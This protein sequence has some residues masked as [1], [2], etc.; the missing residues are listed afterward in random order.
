MT[1]VGEV[2]F[3]R[4]Y[5]K[6]FCGVDGCY[7]ADG[8]LGVEGKRYSKTVQKHCCKLA[9]DVSFAATSE[10]MQEMLGV[11]ICPETVRTVV[12]GHGKEMARFQANDTVSAEAFRKA[13]GAVEFTTDAGKVNTR[14]EGWKD[15][16]IA[17]ISKRLAGE[18]ASPQT[19]DAWK[20][21]RLPAVTIAL[22]FAMIAPAKE[23]R[24]GWRP[25]L[26]RL[27]VRC[28]AEVHALADGASWIWKSV[29]RSLTGC[30]Q[31]L[32]FYH[33]CE[34][35]SKCAER[36]FGE[37]TP[38]TKAAYEK[39]RSHLLCEGWAGICKWVSELYAVADESER[40]RR[41]R[42]IDRMIG[43]FSKHTSRLNYAERLQA[44]RAIGSG[45]IEGE[46][47]TLGLRLKL[48]GARWNRCNVQPMASLVCVRH[49]C[50]WDTYWAVV[51]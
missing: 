36:I 43:Y 22:A 27:G 41:R 49:T 16:K 15:L 45:Q 12:E 32:D 8:V 24:K 46:A 6:C 26:K 17:K 4:R 14:E 34:H 2:T 18:P 19:P 7:A 28:F 47:K 21:Q 1:A 42:P 31:T 37:G 29:Q 5:W 9:S 23:F 3:T 20:K 13:A 39:G 50:Q 40:D 51:A 30:V 10:R 35:L 33:A 11:G 38:E 25:W 48:R 44:G